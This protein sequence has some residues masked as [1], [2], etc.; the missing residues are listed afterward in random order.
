MFFR[1][2]LR[3]DHNLEAFSCGKSAL[4]V[5]LV[6][7]AL[8]ADRGGT[9]RTYVWVND[10]G[11]V[12]AYFALAPHLVRRDDLPRSIARG[13]P[14]MIASILLAKLA[15]ATHLHRQGLGAALLADALAAALAG[16]M[17]VGGRLVVVD[18]IDSEA[19]RFYERH[20][21]VPMPSTPGGRLV[22]KVSDAARS[23]GMEWP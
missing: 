11:D 5:W 2:Q 20:G 12:V 10:I 18:A 22:L 9:S 3:R 6:R 7:S 4:D 1:E 13:A 14:T 19:E 15:L 17:H 16:V 8:D 21:F 23:L